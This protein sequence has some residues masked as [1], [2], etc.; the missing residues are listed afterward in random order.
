ML[1]FIE[2]NKD[3]KFFAYYP[4]V[5]VHAPFVPT[6]D[7]EHWS[8]V[9][10]RT[11]E[12]T[13]FFCDMVK[14]TDKIIGRIEEKLEETGIRENTILIF[15]G[16][17]GTSRRVVSKT[18][19]R[20]IQG[21]KGKTIN[22]GV[23][24]PLLVSWPEGIRRASIFNG[25]IEFSDFFATFADLVGTNVKSDGHSFLPLLKGQRFTAR[26]SAKVH[27]D[28]QWGE[29]V[30]RYRNSFVQTMEYKLYQDGSFYNLEED[31]LEEHH[32]KPE[33]MK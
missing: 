25:L 29:S 2:R 7:S 20:F 10:S 6:P 13:A 4:M 21:A 26:Q 28:P 17:N 5:L 15:T 30:S 18:R 16:D 11:M 32:L 19:N 33:M 1:D 3:E 12:D 31:I 23:H 9:E 22:D 8:D 14:Y 27:Y 24:V